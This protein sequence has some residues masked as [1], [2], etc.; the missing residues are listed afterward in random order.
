MK[1]I[2]ILFVDTFFHK[3]YYKNNLKIKL[4]IANQNIPMR[5]YYKLIFIKSIDLSVA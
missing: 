5:R 3:I 1:K 2:I 4:M